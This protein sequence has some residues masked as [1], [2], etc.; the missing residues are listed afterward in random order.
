[1]YKLP[2]YAERPSESISSTRRKGPTLLSHTSESGIE[3]PTVGSL[4]SP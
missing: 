2:K 4:H 1:M 3:V